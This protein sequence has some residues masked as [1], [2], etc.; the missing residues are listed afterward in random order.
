MKNKK[1]FIMFKYLQGL[2]CGIKISLEDEGLT[3]DQ[4]T[5]IAGLSHKNN[6]HV[7]LKIGGAEAISDMGIGKMI[8]C[9]GCV[10]PM[11]ESAYALH[12]F[13]SSVK[14]KFEFDDLYINIESK[15]AFDNIEEITSHPDFKM[16]S[17]LVLGRSDFVRSLGHTKKEVDSE[18]IYQK[19]KKVFTLA[20]QANKTTLMGGGVNL[21]SYR[22]IKDLYEENLLDYIETRNVK[23]KLS[24]SFLDHFEENLDKMLQFEIQWLTF[25]SQSLSSLRDHDLKRISNLKSFRI[26]KY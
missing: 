24:N 1:D 22:F 5:F 21:H 12:K 26:K 11:I 7:T 23:V 20:K 10:A 13:V 4:A 3:I 14:N 9:S 17:G 16:L 25:K 2:D 19:A 6:M 15:Q 18:Q 8:N